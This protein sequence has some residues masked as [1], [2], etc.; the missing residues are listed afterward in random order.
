MSGTSINAGTFKSRLKK[1]IT[2][3]HKINGDKEYDNSVIKNFKLTLSNKIDWSK[4]AS[5]ATSKLKSSDKDNTSLFTDLSSLSSDKK[6]E[7]SLSELFDVLLYISAIRKHLDYIHNRE[8][9]LLLLVVP[10]GPNLL[11]LKQLNLLCLSH[12]FSIF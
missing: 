4:Y 6:N 12:L 8:V 11:F 10:N 1:L 2:L 9:P 3:K 7:Q 5:V